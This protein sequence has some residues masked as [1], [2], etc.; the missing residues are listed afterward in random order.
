MYFSFRCVADEQRTL[1]LGV[2]S[3]AF[4]LVGAIPGP[5]IFGAI[6]DTACIYWQYECSQRGNCWVYNNIHLSQRAVSLAVLGIG[7]NFLFSLLSWLF[8]PKQNAE[9]KS[10]YV[11]ASLQSDAELDNHPLIEMEQTKPADSI[12]TEDTTKL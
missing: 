3:A 10:L 4:R 2:Q 9:S 12:Q 7:T 1:A 5:P 8:Y 11:G 6:F